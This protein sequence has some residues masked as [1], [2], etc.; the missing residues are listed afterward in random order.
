[1]NYPTGNNKRE[2]NFV[3]MHLRGNQ[4]FE[5][6]DYE[7]LLHTYRTLGGRHA[8]VQVEAEVRL[9]WINKWLKEAEANG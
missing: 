9:W 4:C 7:R 1:M 2:E 3:D 8:R 6:S 5:P